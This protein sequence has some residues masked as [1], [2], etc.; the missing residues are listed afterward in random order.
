[1][2]TARIE[3]V[4]GERTLAEDSQGYVRLSIPP[5]AL[6]ESR[7]GLEP[8]EKVRVEAIIEDNNTHMRLE[9]ADD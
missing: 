7:L 3:K 6:N 4:Y 1:V 5:D 9:A 2:N 8:G